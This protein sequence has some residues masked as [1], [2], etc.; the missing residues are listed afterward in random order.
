MEFK[1][2]PTALS[3]SMSQ[4]W[5]LYASMLGITGE[6]LLAGVAS[7]GCPGLPITAGS[8]VA[9]TDTLCHHAEDLMGVHGATAKPYLRNG[10]SAW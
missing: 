9:K 7:A 3:F 5:Y 10:S 4:I 1:E 6:V 2:L 8:P